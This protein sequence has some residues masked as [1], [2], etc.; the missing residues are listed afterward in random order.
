MPTGPNAH[1]TLSMAGEKMIKWGEAGA[2]KGKPYLD[3]YDDGTGTLTIGWGCTR[4]VTKGMKITEAQAQDM[5]D[6]ELARHVA[7]VHRHIKR[8]IS[9]GLFDALSSFFY[10]HGANAPSMIKAVNGGND[11]EIRK[12]F[13]L[14]VYAYNSKLGKKVPWAGLVNRRTAE[15]QHWAKM[16]AMNPAL[17]TQDVADHTPKSEEPPAPGVIA[18]AAK[19]T[20]VQLQ[21]LGLG[22]LVIGWATDVGKW[23]A[24]LWEAAPQITGEVSTVIGTTQQWS[25]WLGLNGSK[26]IIPMVLTLGVLGIFRYVVRKNEGTTV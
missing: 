19:S 8:P 18:T 15:L 6:V 9:Q 13:M 26:Y 5:L 7:E 14:Y 1:M 16:D 23:A 22:G 2:R 12:A 4:G 21:G 24:G 3:A 25:G 17:P 20:N 11:T 10:N